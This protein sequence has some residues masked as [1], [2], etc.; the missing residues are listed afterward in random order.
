MAQKSEPGNN[1]EICYTFIIKTGSD[2]PIKESTRKWDDGP[3]PSR[4]GVTATTVAGPEMPIGPE[5]LN[6]SGKISATLL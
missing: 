4:G 2:V 1:D 6:F 3:G 5:I